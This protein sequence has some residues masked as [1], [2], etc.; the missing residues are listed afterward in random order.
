MPPKKLPLIGLTMDHSPV[1]DV[2]SFAIGADIYYLNDVY[3][4]YVERV[5][6]RFVGLPTTEKLSVVDDLVGDLDGLLLTGGNHVFAG[7]Y[8]EELSAKQGQYDPP[9]TFFEIALIKSALQLNKPIYGI[10]RGCQM[11]NVA[12]GGSL[13]QDIPTQLTQV[14]EHRSL[15]KPVWNFHS[16]QIKSGTVLS[17]ILQQTEARVSS[18]HVQAINK[19]GSGLTVAAQAP[20]GI[21]EAIEIAGKKF[22]IGVQ[23]H[24]EVMDD[25]PV[26]LR[27]LQ[28]FINACAKS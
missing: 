20:D 8:G 17:H 5:L 18:S 21:V 1:K 12:M 15:N 9:R 14:G 2:R 28:A 26:A 7:A 23:W 16:V 3:V 4:R 27:L 11:L 25:D 6:C 13:Y 22:V 19:I 24:P 10:C